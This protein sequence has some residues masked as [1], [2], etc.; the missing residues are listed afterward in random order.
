MPADLPSLT[1]LRW[2]AAFGVFGFHVLVVQYFGG[3]GAQVMGVVFGAG[4][5]CVALFFVL[6]GF[7][8]TWGS[9]H[10]SVRLFW[11]RR[12]ARLWPLHLVGV[13]LALVVA[14]TTVPGIRT[15][16]PVSELA[17]VFLVST[18]HDAWWQAG[19][20]VSWPLACEA[21]FALVFPLLHAGLRR[22]AAP[23]VTGVAVLTLLATFASPTLSAQFPGHPSAYSSPLMRLPEFVL[24]IACALLM[25]DH[26]WSDPPLGVA[27]PAAVL[28][29][30]TSS[31]TV[32]VPLPAGA[33][34]TAI[35][36]AGYALL[37]CGLARTD[38]RGE[39]S[40]L[41]TRPFQVLG[42]LSFAFYLVHLL[43]IASV[44]SP[45]PDGHPQIAWAPA[46]LLALTSL[47]IALVVAVVLHRGVEVPMRRWF[48]G[49]TGAHRVPGTG[50][51][52]IST[53][54]AAGR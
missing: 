1:G 8:I 41:A 29:Y 50:R 36:V 30:L 2:L 38:V 7:V 26:S 28:G 34:P 3:T 37:V 23:I 14:F 16:D 22:C 21:F 9:D 54:R 43:V 12:V 39:R 49:L 47:T 18:W 4:S 10:A 51:S 52:D 24:G 32:P 45:W 27:I 15:T 5:S 33:D 6:S 46:A 40:V 31:G 53:R 17:N 25:R 42:R 48:L 35:A 11:L 13:L 19:N 20:P 44:S